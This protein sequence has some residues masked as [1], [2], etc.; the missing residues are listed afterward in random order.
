MAVH[1]L[2]VCFYSSLLF[3]PILLWAW[4]KGYFDGKENMHMQFKLQF[5]NKKNCSFFLET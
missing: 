3:V 4:G 5:C 1:N 2:V